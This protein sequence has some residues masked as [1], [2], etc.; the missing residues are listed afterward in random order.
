VKSL[1][2]TIAKYM[3]MSGALTEEEVILLAQQ[4]D[5]IYS[6]SSTL[7]DIL[8]NALHPSTEQPKPTLN[9]HAYGVIGSVNN[10]IVD[11]VIEKLGQMSIHSPTTL[12]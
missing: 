3:A 11:K 7:Y 6:Q 8:P 10:T 4:L 9:P 5:L 1:L 2:P 12:S